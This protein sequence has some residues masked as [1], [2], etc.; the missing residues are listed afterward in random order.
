MRTIFILISVILSTTVTLFSQPG[1]F[2]LRM[3]M[4]LDQVKNLTGKNPEM[5]EDNVYKVIPPD[6]HNMFI[7]YRVR[8]SPTYGIVWIYAESKEIETDDD[9]T[10]LKNAFNDLVSSIERTY[11]KYIRIDRIKNEDYSSD[12]P[13]DFMFDL[14]LEDR[15]L[16]AYWTKTI[17]STLPNDIA[18]ISLD[19]HA[20]PV[21]VG[22]ITL[23]YLSPN[24]DIAAAED[25]AKQDAVF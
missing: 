1:P 3:G 10:Q 7:E 6:T 25:K 21:P 23:Q 22:Y 17:D 20:L 18:L 9:G 14:F 2:G 8:I 13:E 5:L 24:H 11:G 4:T 12:E 15:E 19:A 16:Q